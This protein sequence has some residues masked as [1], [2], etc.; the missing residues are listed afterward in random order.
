MVNE[1]RLKSVV[2]YPYIIHKRSPGFDVMGLRMHPS[3][4]EREERDFIEKPGNRFSVIFM[5]KEV[6]FSQYQELIDTIKKEDVDSRKNRMEYI[7]ERLYSEISV[8]IGE[9]YPGEIVQF[10]PIQEFQK[11]DFLVTYRLCAKVY[12]FDFKEE[13]M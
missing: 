11:E 13:E 8:L 5:V 9:K 10:G 1:K 2:R 7:R 6:F 4:I 3:Q 12:D